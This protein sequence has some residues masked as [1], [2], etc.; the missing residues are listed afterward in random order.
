M[1]IKT[2]FLT[3]N[4]LILGTLCCFGLAA[5]TTS[6]PKVPNWGHHTNGDGPLGH[7][8]KGVEHIE[9]PIIIAPPVIDYTPPPAPI[10]AKNYDSVS[11][12]F[13]CTG[14]F[15]LQGANG[16]IIATGHAY[17]APEGLYVLDKNGA[18]TGK[19]INNNLGSSLIFSPDCGCNKIGN[20][21]PETKFSGPLPSGMTCK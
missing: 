1:K 16:Q 12:L 11:N 5:C 15:S 7:H 21:I 4:I 9:K 18:K 10:I 13:G 3:K 8:E 17:N 2:Q 19:I 6:E 20:V 14:A